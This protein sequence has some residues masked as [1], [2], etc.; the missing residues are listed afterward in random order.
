MDYSSKDLFGNFPESRR[1]KTASVRSGF[2]QGNLANQFWKDLY[3][4]LSAIQG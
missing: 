3:F 4:Q 1:W 2:P